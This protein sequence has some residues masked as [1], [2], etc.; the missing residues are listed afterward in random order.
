MGIGVIILMK[1]IPENASQQIA[2][3]YQFGGAIAGLI[4]GLLLIF[5]M[6]LILAPYRQRNE[7]RVL[8]IESMQKKIHITN[9]D[10]L[11]RAIS[12]FVTSATKVFIMD[13]AVREYGDNLGELSEEKKTNR[14]IALREYAESMQILDAERLVAG[15][16]IGTIIHKEIKEFTLEQILFT[17]IDSTSITKLSVEDFAEELKKRLAETLRQINELTS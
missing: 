15:E 4:A 16:I 9:R 8:L 3:I 17:N 11:I 7:A 2:S 10:T 1:F 14:I 6:Y 13:E 5:I 12:G